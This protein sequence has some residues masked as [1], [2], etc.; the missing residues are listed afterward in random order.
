MTDTLVK[1]SKEHQQVINIP[2]KID[3]E[4][5]LQSLG[6]N[7]RTRAAMEKHLDELIAMAQAAVK[8]R[9]MFKVSCVGGRGDDWV[10]VD[11]VRINSKVLANSLANTDTVFPY[12]FTVGK[13]LDELPVSP[14]D[15][16]RYFCM[17][18]VKMNASLQAARYFMKYIQ[19]KYDLPEITHL[20]PGEFSD[21]PIEEQVPLFSLFHDTEK[22]IGVKL[23]STKTIQPIKSGSGIVFSN[24]SSFESC[25][26]CLMAKCPG[27][28]VPYSPRLAAQFG[29]KTKIKK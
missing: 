5:V 15:A 6:K 26:L 27:R 2:V 1:T 28:R 17:E 14:K 9:G 8:A 11:G 18:A 12:I 13:E 19:Q 22:E 3:R 21:L 10:E 24:G 7:E 4:E 25:A 16:M 20:H 23:T 29:L